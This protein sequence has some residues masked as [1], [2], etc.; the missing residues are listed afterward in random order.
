MAEKI[1]GRRVDRRVQRSV[2]RVIGEQRQEKQ[3]AT[4]QHSE[5]ERLREPELHNRKRFSACPT[6]C[7]PGYAVPPARAHL[8]ILASVTTTAGFVQIWKAHPRCPSAG[9]ASDLWQ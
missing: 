6:N 7:R 3:K 9:T 8:N 5:A 4:Q 2:A 1:A